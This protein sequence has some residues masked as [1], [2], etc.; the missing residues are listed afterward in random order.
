MN[1]LIKE[2]SNL[3]N[4]SKYKDVDNLIKEYINNTIDFDLVIN[5]AKNHE[6][7]YNLIIRFYFGINLKKE[8]DINKNLDFIYKNNY[9]LKDWSNVDSLLPFISKIPLD[10]GLKHYKLNIKS[11][12]EYARRWAYVL[13]IKNL[14]K[15]ENNFLTILD[16]FKDDESYYVKMA[17]AWLISLLATISS[18]KTYNYLKKTNLSESIVLKAIQKILDS[19]IINSADKEKIKKI[20]L[21]YKEL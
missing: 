1:K 16:L 9:L 15:D 12:N 14:Y 18:Q 13:F 10:L 8:K 19:H 6:Y 5:L 3:D 11:K 4:K 17:E 20:R 21:R 7:N 2:L